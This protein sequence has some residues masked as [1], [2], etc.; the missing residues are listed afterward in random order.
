M[1]TPR[2]RSRQPKQ[3]DAGIFQ[4]EISS[5]ALRLAA[6]GKAAKTIRTYTEAVRWFAAARLPSRASWEQVS[7]QDIQRWMAWLL[8]RHSS[9]YA[10]NQYQASQQ[11][12]KW[13]AAEDEL[14]DPMAG[15]QPPRVTDKLVPVFTPEELARLEQ[16]CA[17]RS[18]AQRR[19]TAIIAVFT[20]TGIRLSELASLQCSDVDLWQRE[21]TVRGKDRIVRIG[22][23]AARSLDRYQRARTRRAQAWRPQLWLGARNREPPLRRQRPQ[24]P[25]PPHLRPHHD[26]HLTP[27]AA[28]P[29]A[30][31]WALPRRLAQE[32]P[33]PGRQPRTRARADQLPANL[34]A[35]RESAPEA[36]VPG[37]RMASYVS[38]ETPS[39]VPTKIPQAISSGGWSRGRENGRGAGCGGRGSLPLGGWRSCWRAGARVGES[40]YGLPVTPADFG[41]RTRPQA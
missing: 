10:S 36:G 4:A 7:S 14:P 17:G 24:R 33:R 9:A 18:F 22:H 21:I 16:A 40:E 13:L 31:V 39:A 29:L 1:S 26:R 25:R 15:L 32:R 38:R 23:Q 28:I 3:L 41:I 27:P 30:L 19:D 35:Q 6:E 12:F 34:R 37:L 11:F 2:P 20:A 8:D 5:F